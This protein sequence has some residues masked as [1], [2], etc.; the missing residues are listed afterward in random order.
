MNEIISDDSSYAEREIQFWI[1]LEYIQKNI[2]FICKGI[3]YALCFTTWYGN[4]KQANSHYS[5][6]K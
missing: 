4:P 3:V 5:D 1:S 2:Q 6:T